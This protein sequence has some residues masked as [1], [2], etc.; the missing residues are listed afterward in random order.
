MEQ[1][2]VIE[3]LADCSVTVFDVGSSAE[4][5]S[6]H[7][8]GAWWGVR[9]RLAEAL[10]ALSAATEIVIASGDGMLAQLAAHDVAQL[11]PGLNVR[12][13][14]GGTQAWIN[15]GLSTANGVERPTCETDDVWYKPY[16][17]SNAV[18]T[19]MQDYL[20]WEVDLVP[21]IERDGDACFRPL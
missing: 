18:R 7:I 17:Q 9:S 8:P 10:T 21:Q 15:A 20:K 5:R 12:V 4:Y 11:R 1:H 13:L 14:I 16:E 2:R 19:A 6:K 3:A